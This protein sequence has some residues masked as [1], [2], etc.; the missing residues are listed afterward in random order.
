V[1]KREFAFI[2]TLSSEQ[3]AKLKGLAHHLKPLVQIGNQGFSE[4]VKKEILLALEKHELIKVQ[5]PGDSKADSKDEKQ[6]ELLTLLPKHA[7]LVSRIGRTIILY[8]EKDP[9]ERK[10]NL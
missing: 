10:I 2:E 6:N 5:L 7:H 4:S 3:K 8:L 1:K 9:T